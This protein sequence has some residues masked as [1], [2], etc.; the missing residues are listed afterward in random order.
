MMGVGRSQ[1]DLVSLPGTPV[2][3]RRGLGRTVQS[4]E[5]WEH[6]GLPSLTLLCRRPELC[7][8]C[9]IA[10]VSARARN[11]HMEGTAGYTIVGRK[12][13]GHEISK[14]RLVREA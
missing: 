11:Q 9:L 3:R 12:R 8:M 10:G 6:E 4:P 5:F 1:D 13:G 2:C 7:A 14:H